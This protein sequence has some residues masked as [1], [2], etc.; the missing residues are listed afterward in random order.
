MKC[1]DSMEEDLPNVR[2]EC[3]ACGSPMDI[4]LT[5]VNTRWGN[6]EPVIVRDIKTYICPNCRHKC[7]DM[8]EMKRMENKYAHTPI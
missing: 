7:F 4:A 5:D 8:A 3:I 1:G 2:T 6:N